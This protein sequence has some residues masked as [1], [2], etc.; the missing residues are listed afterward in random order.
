MGWLAKVQKQIKID[1]SRA[2]HHSFRISGSPVSHLSAFSAPVFVASFATQLSL[3]NTCH[4]LRHCPIGSAAG[5]PRNFRTTVLVGIS[6]GGHWPLA[7]VVV[8]LRVVITAPRGFGANERLPYSRVVVDGGTGF[9]HSCLLEVIDGLKKRVPG[10][11]GKAVDGV[12]A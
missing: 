2:E 4:Y 3:T 5:N 10:S 8:S 1:K 7:T 9:F 11:F 6:P 12:G